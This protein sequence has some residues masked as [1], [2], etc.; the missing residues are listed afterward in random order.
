MGGWVWVSEDGC[1]MP[2]T[3]G[4]PIVS[5]QQVVLI[6]LLHWYAVQ[7]QLMPMKFQLQN[8]ITS[9]LLNHYIIMI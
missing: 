7:L 5:P 8:I 3:Q 1:T 9:P 6:T 4:P 2:P